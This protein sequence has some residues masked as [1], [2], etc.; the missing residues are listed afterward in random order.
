MLI[1]NQESGIKFAENWKVV[2]DY[3]M[4]DETISISDNTKS[5]INRPRPVT[6]SLVSVDIV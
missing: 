2:K 1:F 3:V 5:V 6:K 4:A